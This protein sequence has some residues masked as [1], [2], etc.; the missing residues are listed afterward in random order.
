MFNPVAGRRVL[1]S[2]YS[3]ELGGMELRMADEARLLQESGSKVVVASRRI[4]ALGPWIMKLR[5]D[6]IDVRYL[7]VPPAF[8]Q[9]R[10]RRVNKL[11]GEALSARLIQGW[12]CDLNHI[13][14]P[15]TDLGGSLLW[16]SHKARLP[17]VLSV[18][19]AFPPHRFHP[20]YDRLFMNAYE[21]VKGVYAVSQSAL[22][23]Y[24]AT[25]GRYLSPD[26][27]CRVIP[28][29]V[30]TSRFRPSAARRMDARARLE[31]PEGTLVLG[32]VGRLSEQKRPEALLRVFARLAGKFPDLRL[33]LIGDGPLKDQVTALAQRL[34]V[35]G[36]L[37]I[38][39]YRDD[40]E[41]LIP[42]FDIHVLLSSR[43]GFGIAT[44][45]AMACGVP[46]VGSNVPGT[47]DILRDGC[48]GVL[49]SADDEPAIADAIERLL[50]SPGERARVGGAGRELVERYYNLSLWKQRVSGFYA[51][52]MAKLKALPRRAVVE[53]AA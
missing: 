38:T 4:S 29:F 17:V 7:T 50:R 39:G 51:D 24:R 45:E 40:V 28:N 12:R 41:A 5:K 13:F 11:L 14:L 15:W 9:W 22:D 16:V 30:D 6:G 52:V 3:N 43:E 26:I 36:R 32:S 48:G 35:V 49:V 42:A 33:V 46:V 31:I 1:I 47:A 53:T 34:G 8:E 44:A 25:F 20:W 19:N 2:S 10:W 37:H 23:H 27:P 21:S 18:H